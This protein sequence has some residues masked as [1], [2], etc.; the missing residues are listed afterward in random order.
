[1]RFLLWLLFS[2]LY[3]IAV[4]ALERGGIR[5]GMIPVILLYGGLNV[6]YGAL[7]RSW[8]EK[9]ARERK[10]K[11]KRRKK[12][13][14]A[15]SA[16]PEYMQEK[17]PTRTTALPQEQPDKADVI[18]YLYA[19]PQ[20][21]LTLRCMKGDSVVLGRGVQCDMVLDSYNAVSSSHC[22]ITVDKDS[23]TVTDIGSANGTVVDGKRIMP[24]TSVTAGHDSRIY[25][26]N[27]VCA[28]QVQ[29][30]P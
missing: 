18:L 10:R 7:C 28:I 14:A 4:V 29:I 27:Q 20:A 16:R 2:V 6:V 1:M 24:Y 13:A 12:R 22:R 11:R 9:K 17:R 30:N 19:G 25:L 21:G 5:L 26:G 23:V 15:A 8:D 3:A